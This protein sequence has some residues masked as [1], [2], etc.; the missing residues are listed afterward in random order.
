MNMFSRYQYSILF[1]G[2]RAGGLATGREIDTDTGIDIRDGIIPR[3]SC[4]ACG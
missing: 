3:M 1:R 4:S 2:G